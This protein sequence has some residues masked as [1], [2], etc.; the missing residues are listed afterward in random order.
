[1]Y[2][3]FSYVYLSIN[4]INFS[5]VENNM[6]VY[7]IDK[8]KNNHSIFIWLVD[9]KNFQYVNCIEENERYYI[10]YYNIE[11]YDPYEY[12]S[13]CGNNIINTSLCIPYFKISKSYNS[14]V[15]INKIL[16][17]NSFQ[18]TLLSY[19][20]DNI[21]Y[22]FENI[23]FN[24]QDPYLCKYPYI[25]IVPGVPNWGIR[26]CSD[27]FLDICSHCAITESCVYE[28]NIPRCKSN[29]L[30]KDICPEGYSC[31][32]DMDGNT[33]CIYTSFQDL[34]TTLNKSKIINL[35]LILFILF[36]IIL[37]ILSIVF[38][39]RLSKKLNH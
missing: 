19:D 34:E 26:N 38:Q 10:K 30:C 8:N 37:I 13:Y 17:T 4:C 7:C 25:E 24:L 28:N 33:S 39:K 35:I 29:Y 16:S 21:V 14:L 11:N 22:S 15:R 2:T 5:L 31:V 36:F 32:V 20:N 12:L 1:M 18:G 9:R 6:F 3:I 27:K 23:I